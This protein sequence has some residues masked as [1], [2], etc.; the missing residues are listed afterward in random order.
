MDKLVPGP[1]KIR[2]LA[3]D[4][5]GPAALGWA[6]RNPERTASAILMNTGTRF[7]P[8]YEMPKRLSFFKTFPTLG[9]FF[10]KTLGLF[11]EGFLL[12]CSLRPLS[13]TVLDGFLAPYRSRFLRES[14]ASFVRDIPLSPK[15]PSFGTLSSLDK[16]LPN[17]SRKP[18]LL[19]WGLADA[20]FN[21]RF[22]HDLKK[23]LPGAKITALPD[24]GHLPLEDEP[25]KVLKELKNFWTRNPRAS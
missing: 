25:A 21:G 3:H 18:V 2:L 11:N 20:V 5:G 19:L 22:L 16:A 10:A 9:G 14:V 13:P 17:L 8:G 12:Q 1:A 4:W 23:R 6:V 24:S 15:H 7:P